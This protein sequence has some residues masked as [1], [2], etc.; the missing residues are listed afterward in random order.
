MNGNSNKGAQESGGKRMEA[1][2][3]V[4]GHKVREGDSF[5]DD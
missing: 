3:Y 1:I 5:T 4:I 2:K